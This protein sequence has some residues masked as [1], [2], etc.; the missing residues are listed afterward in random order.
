M[1][2]ARRIPPTARGVAWHV[3]VRVDRDSAYADLALHAA[4]REI[5]L[6]R[7]DRAFAT[8]LCY[9]GLR[10][11]GRLDAALEKVLDRPLEHIELP[12]LNLLRLGAYQILFLGGVR[13]AAAV[14][15]SVELAKAAGLRRADGFVNAVLRSLVREADSI[16]FPSLDEDPVG[17]LVQW[18]SLPEWLAERWLDQFGASEA[19]ALAEACTKPPPRTIRVSEWADLEGVAKRLGGRRCRYAPRGLTGL[20]TDPVRDPGFERGE[21]SVQDEAAQLV[22]LLLGAG[23]GETVVDCCA[24]P[25]GKALQ[26]AELVGAK[27]EVVALDSNPSRLGLI[28]RAAARLGLRNVRALE[29]DASEGFDLRGQQHFKRILVDAPCSGLGVLRRNPDARWRIPGEDVVHSAGTQLAILSSAARYVEREGI[30]VYSV[31]TTSPEETTGVISRFLEL[32]PDFRVDDS[33]P[34][35]PPAAAELIDAEGVLR[36]FP[37]K[38]GCDAFYA[39]RLVSA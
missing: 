24:A 14:S 36:T 4:L 31:C 20:R 32:H 29:R 1:S 19:A 10:L 35:L 33:R 6:G 38:H 23:E 13:S 5:D 16:S 9:G 15:E 39:V 30:L 37:H 3:L 21:F 18:G 22:P 17:Y 2:P 28:H 34:E 27:G 12:L 7:R 11:R 8:E 25:G 26:L